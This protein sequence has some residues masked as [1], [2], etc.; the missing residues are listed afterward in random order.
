MKYVYKNDD[1]KEINL[2]IVK[3]DGDT[4]YFEESDEILITSEQVYDDLVSE[5]SLG[6]VHYLAAH[7]IITDRYS[8]QYENVSWEP[9]N[10][11]LRQKLFL[12]LEELRQNAGD[13]ENDTFYNDGEPW[14]IL[15]I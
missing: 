7:E 14:V 9:L 4:T 15:K 12:Y 13:D 8:T 5:I 11:E 10:K 2:K 1:G 3:V 6:G